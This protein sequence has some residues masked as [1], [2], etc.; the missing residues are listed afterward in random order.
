MVW[1]SKSLE[2]NPENNHSRR[3]LE[4]GVFFY[5]IVQQGVKRQRFSYRLKSE[6][7]TNKMQATERGFMWYH[8][9]YCARGFLPIKTADIFVKRDYKR[10]AEAGLSWWLKVKPQN[11]NAK[12]CSHGFVNRHGIIW[13][14]SI[15]LWCCPLYTTSWNNLLLLKKC[16]HFCFVEEI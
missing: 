4:S 3:K 1:A 15:F 9:T 14:S 2:K 12:G 11:N 6:S 16:T 13:W 5:S 7:V 8:L 10:I